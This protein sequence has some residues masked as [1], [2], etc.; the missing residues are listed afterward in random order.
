MKSSLQKVETLEIIFWDCWCIDF[1]IQLQ[2]N[3][4]HSVHY[5]RGKTTINSAISVVCICVL[6]KHCCHKVIT[7]LCIPSKV[8]LSVIKLMGQGQNWRDTR[9]NTYMA[10]NIASR[11]FRRTSKRFPLVDIFS[12]L[13]FIRWQKKYIKVDARKV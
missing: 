9:H 2:N 4:G 7:V 11:A 13:L 6:L 12:H 10:R 3:F 8:S 5:I 1:Q